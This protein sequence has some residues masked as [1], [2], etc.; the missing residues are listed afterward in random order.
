MNFEE[1]VIVSANRTAI[2]RFGGSLKNVSVIDMSSQLLKKMFD[3]IALDPTI[4]DEVYIG[5]VLS[6]GLGQN[7]ARQIAI[8]SG[9][10]VKTPATTINQVCGSGMKAVMLAA[11]SIMIGENEIVVAGGCENMSQ[12]PY[13]LANHRWGHK[14]GNDSMIDTL[15]FDGLTDAFED[16]HMGMTAENLADQYNISRPE[17]DT[18]ALKSQKKAEKANLAGKFIQ[19]IIPIVQNI[20]G[21]AVIFKEDEN[22]RK[23]QTMDDL[24]KLRP[25]FK[26]D[27]TVTAGNSSTL[28]DGA[29]FLLMMSRSKA[30]DLGLE[31]MASICSM[32]KAGVEPALM[33]TAPIPASKKALKNAGLTLEDIDLIEGNEAFAV[34]SLVVNQELGIDEEKINVNGGAIALGHPIGCSGAR[35][36]VTLIHEMKRRNAHLGLA[37]LCIGGGQGN[38]VIVERELK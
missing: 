20:G 21:Q 17:Q 11:Q 6:A 19:E 34:Q 4:I 22:I 3:N 15:V 32:G 33:G 18:F 23:D 1:V 27:G 29:A 38:A 26:K 7:V 35:I 24:V 12:A 28:N 30:E 13:V 37:T 36:L 14:L 2:G 5:N 25:V 9:I 16:Y 10:S 8:Q 31:I